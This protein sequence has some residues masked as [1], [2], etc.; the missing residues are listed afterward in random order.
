MDPRHVQL[1]QASL[2]KIASSDPTGDIFADELLRIA[3]EVTGQ[4]P[5]IAYARRR[6]ALSLMAAA[7]RSLH[8]PEGILH[9]IRSLTPVGE[10]GVEAIQPADYDY[11]GNALLKTLRIALGPE[12]TSD[13]WNAWVEALCNLADILS[14]PMASVPAAPATRAA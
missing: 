12:F 6:R 3:P 10:I 11:A 7:V 2:N 8:M 1:V 14:K 13:V 4:D 5:E 9:E